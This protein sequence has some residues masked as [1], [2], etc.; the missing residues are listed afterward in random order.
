MSRQPRLSPPEAMRLVLG[1]EY[2]PNVKVGVC[3]MVTPALLKVELVRQFP[4]LPAKAGEAPRIPRVF[5]SLHVMLAE[6]TAERLAV[7][8][9]WQQEDLM[10]IRFS[11]AEKMAEVARTPDA[12]IEVAKA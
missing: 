1:Y 8:L 10:D 3:Q 11:E 12:L 5:A 6:W 9:E 7:A 4:S 2:N